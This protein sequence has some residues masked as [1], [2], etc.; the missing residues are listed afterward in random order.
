LIISHKHRFVFIK[1][2]KTASSSIEVALSEVCGPDDIIT[3]VPPEAHRDMAEPKLIAQNQRHN[4]VDIDPHCSGKWILEN[5]PDVQDYVWFTVERHP[6]TKCLSNYHYQLGRLQLQV[7]KQYNFNQFLDSDEVPL[8]IDLWCNNGVPIVEGIMRFE[9]IDAD[10]KQ[11]CGFLNITTQLP[12]INKNYTD[13]YPE[14]DP[15]Q[16]QKINKLFHNSNKF[17]GYGQ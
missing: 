1:T 5:I 7:A 4:G 16:K 17:T 14:I 2:R 6:H 15:L 11:L 3:E 13:E 9:H 8:D 12:H 10:F